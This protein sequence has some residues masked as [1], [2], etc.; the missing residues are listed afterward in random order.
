MDM[1]VNDTRQ[2]KT[3][4]GIDHFIERCV[5]VLPSGKNLGNTAILYDDGS[6]ERL[7]FIYKC[8]S[9]D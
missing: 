6:V 9:V 4:R 1:I 8:S 7:P 5:G 3:S 2:N